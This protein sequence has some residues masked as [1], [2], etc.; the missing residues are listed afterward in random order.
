MIG[1]YLSNT[2]ERATV[3]ILQNILELNQAWAAGWFSLIFSGPVCGVS[4]VHARVRGHV[5]ADA[6]MSADTNRGARGR[7]CR[8]F[9]SGPPPTTLR[10]PSLE[11]KGPSVHRAWLLPGTIGAGRKESQSALVLSCSAGMAEWLVQQ[12]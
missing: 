4:F 2:N 1:Q 11:S 6:C 7:S 12:S 9:P 8:A 5:R 3:S 10:P